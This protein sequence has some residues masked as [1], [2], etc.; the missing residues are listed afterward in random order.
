M[1]ASIPR[2]IPVPPEAFDSRARARA[3]Q[4]VARWQ[5]MPVKLRML[6]DECLVLLDSRP[7]ETT[8]GIFLAPMLRDIPTTGTV[9]AVGP[10]CTSV[11]V[12]D[13]VVFGK[14]NG[15]PIDAERFGFPPHSLYVM[16]PV[17]VQRPGE[18]EFIH[19]AQDH[20]Q[21]VIDDE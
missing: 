2:A 16:R 10:R 21:A 15:V 12:G 3:S 7:E 17:Y 19:A 8:G 14:G 5:A 9:L 13:R 6:R 18:R 1:N 11:A 20:I 4:D